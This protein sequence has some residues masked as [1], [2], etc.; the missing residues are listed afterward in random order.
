MTNLFGSSNVAKSASES[1]RIVA[2]GQPGFQL[3]ERVTQ[4]LFLAPALIYLLLFFGYPAVVSVLMSLQHYTTSSFLTGEA[5]FN[6]FENYLRVTRSPLFAITIY[7]TALFTTGSIIGQF[8]LGLALALFFHRKFPLS[9]VMRSLLLLPWLLPAIASTAVWRWILDR[10]SGV[11]N[12][13]LTRS[14][15]APHVVPW[16]TSPS[17][18][19]VTVIAVNIW[20]GI[21]F[22]LTI[23]YGGLNAIPSDFYEAAALDGAT[24]WQAFRY[25]TWPM[26][27]GVVTVVL[28]LGVVYTLKTLDIILGLT[29]GGPANATQTMATRAYQVSFI[30]FD[31]G[32]GAAWANLLV[33]VALVFSLIY[34]RVRRP[35]AYS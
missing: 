25:I 24:G 13:V 32:T 18:A 12:E 35:A 30:E 22:N 33:V 23:L 8:G 34:L 21:P 31:F 2:F 28:V 5:P 11:L 20:I 3:W 17:V 9:R 10:D 7:N 29:H 6:G 26:L 4:W 16:L 14:H 27:R 1:R 19:L 15:I